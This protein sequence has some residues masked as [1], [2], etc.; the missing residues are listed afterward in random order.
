ME[1]KHGGLKK[2]FGEF[3]KFI[4]R[5]NVLDMAVGVIVGG[6][7]T[8]IVTALSDNILKPL[9]NWV[10]ALILGKDALSEV[11]TFLK[12][13]YDANGV[14]SLEKFHLHRLGRFYQRH[15]QFPAHRF[16]ALLHRQSDQ[17]LCRSER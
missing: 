4:T 8:A 3:K 16:R 10:L 12:R 7:F 2:F 17:Q 6:A 13:G 15:H 11:F 9:I 14:L 1:K 5:G